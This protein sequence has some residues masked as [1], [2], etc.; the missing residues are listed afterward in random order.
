MLISWWVKEFG[1]FNY[2]VYGGFCFVNMVMVGFYMI[3]S[4]FWEFIEFDWDWVD[5]FFLFG[6]VEDYVLNFIKKGI[7]KLK[8]WG[9]KFV[10]VNLV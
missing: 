6:V 10:F 5:Y 2:V 9:V 1:I 7:L 3:G 4:V 8:D